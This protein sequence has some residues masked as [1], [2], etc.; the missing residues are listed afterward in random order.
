MDIFAT[1]IL[2]RVVASLLSPP[3]SLL[4]RYFTEQ[5]TSDREE[6]NFDVDTKKRRIAPFVSPLVEGKVVESRGFTTKT[7]KPAYVKDKR[8]FDA[9][10]PFKRAM[11]EQI[12]GSL[13]PEQRLNAVLMAD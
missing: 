8:R 12:A 13:T 1:A 2:N 6:I 10:R 4:D 3:S 11:G 7:F 9:Q 5:Q